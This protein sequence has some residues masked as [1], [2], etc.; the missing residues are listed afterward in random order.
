MARKLRLNISATNVLL[1]SIPLVA[2][3]SLT[4]ASELAA[5][6][7]QSGN[8][9]RPPAGQ[10]CPR[11][12]YVVG[13]DAAANIVCSP[14]CDRGAVDTDTACDNGNMQGGHGCPPACQAEATA[15]VAGAGVAGTQVG[16]EEPAPAPA[17][18]APAAPVPEA[19]VAQAAAPA[20]AELTIEEVEPSS[21]VWGTRELTIAV[22]GAGFTPESVVLFSGSTYEPVVDPSGTRLTVTLP[23]RDLPLG[24]Y[25]VTVSD[26]AGQQ[27]T[28]KR[29]LIVY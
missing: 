25:A 1:A 7:P 12:S 8:S 10:M 2:M 16:H 23:T 11:G 17:V 27:D 15:A 21:V 24:N 3:V 4:T 29:A 9:G 28:L 14:I 6:E 26:G 5:A 13:F 22:I 20:I 18:A 19:A